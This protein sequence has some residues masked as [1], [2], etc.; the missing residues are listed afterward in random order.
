MDKII[1]HKTQWNTNFIQ[2]HHHFTTNFKAP[3]NSKV[4]YT[5]LVNQGWSTASYSSLSVTQMKIYS[6]KY[7]LYDSFTRD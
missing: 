1:T 2:K 3:R 7:F 6:A 4:K 5:L